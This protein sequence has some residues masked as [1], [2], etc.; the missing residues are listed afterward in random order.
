[1]ANAKTPRRR[2]AKG[3]GGKAGKEDERMEEAI[4]L[5]RHLPSSS[6]VFSSYLGVLAFAFA[7]LQNR[8][9]AA[10][11]SGLVRRVSRP[12]QVNEVKVGAVD[13]GPAQI[14]AAE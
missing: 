5:P 11:V 3:G 7:R 13:L 12:A 10:E 1:M 2:D 9:A 4:P 14:R 6:L 8:P